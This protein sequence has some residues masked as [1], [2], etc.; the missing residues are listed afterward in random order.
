MAIKSGEVF[1][2]V[3]FQALV[4]VINIVLPY[5]KA[6]KNKKNNIWTLFEW[7]FSVMENYCLSIIVLKTIILCNEILHCVY[8]L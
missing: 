2:A 6:K 8:F 4:I 5:T 3:M 7:S 1:K